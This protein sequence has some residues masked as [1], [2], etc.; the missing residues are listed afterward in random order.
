MLTFSPHSERLVGVA[1]EEWGRV[2]I[3]LFGFRS[4]E[5]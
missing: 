4:H 5:E 3:H 2:N 1:N